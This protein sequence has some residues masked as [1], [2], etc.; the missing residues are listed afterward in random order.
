MKKEDCKYCDFMSIAT[1][2]KWR[3]VPFC[4]QLGKPIAEIEVCPE[5]LTEEK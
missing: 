5:T 1:E 4:N 3:G 2:P